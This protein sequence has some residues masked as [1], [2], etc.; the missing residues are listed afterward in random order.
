[1]RVGLI[2]RQVLRVWFTS[3]FHWL[4]IFSH[5]SRKAGRQGGC[6]EAGD[7]GQDAQLGWMNDEGT[8]YGHGGPGR[9]V[10][11]RDPPPPWDDL[12]GGEVWSGGVSR[13][14]VKK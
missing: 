12:D 3:V 9:P 11:A 7:K 4:S 8:K 13:V 5:R 6:R 1:M 10:Q 2:E 14:V